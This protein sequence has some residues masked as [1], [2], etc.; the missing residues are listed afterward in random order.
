MG[1]SGAT[2]PWLEIQP[3]RSGSTAGFLV[4]ARSTMTPRDVRATFGSN[5]ARSLRQANGR[6]MVVLAERLTA[7][8]REELERQEVNYV[9]LAGNV[10]LDDGAI[11]VRLEEGSA[12]RSR[13]R[14]SNRTGSST[15]R[16]AKVGQVVR[17]LVDGS[18]EPATGSEIATAAGVTEG[19]VS[20]ILEQLEGEGLIDRVPRGP[21]TRVDW[22]AL[23]RARAASQLLL[24]RHTTSYWI[25]PRGVTGMWELLS[26]L[27]SEGK[28]GW[29]LSGSLVAHDI[30]PT[31]APALAVVRSLQ[32]EAIA[33]RLGLLP[34][35]DVG[36]VALVRLEN[37][38][39]LERC[40]VRRGVPCVGYSQLVIDCLSGPGR[41]PAEGE[42]VIEW[43]HANQP[44]WRERSVAEM[45]P[46]Q[47][48]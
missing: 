32:P 39:S 19:Y 7:A 9:D 37:Y 42:A 40:Q 24:A 30:V 26:E 41:M 6:P 10:L 25:S 28:D 18:A 22:P 27:G 48:S 21:V 12:P 1:F 29:A 16:G 20:R 43:M 14:P 45:N 5:I 17:V 8:A 35:D 11:F 23:L 15:L 4:E 33:A 38:G 47:W 46:G 3:P 2:L 36:D 34:S 44:A 13:L 31:A